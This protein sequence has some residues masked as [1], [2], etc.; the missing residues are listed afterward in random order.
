MAFSKANQ[1]LPQE[2]HF[3][4][5]GKILSHPVRIRILRKILEGGAEGATFNQINTGIPLDD[6]TLS[7]HFEY[8]RKMKIITSSDFKRTTK[9]FI[10]PELDFTLY[11]I[12]QLILSVPVIPDEDEAYDLHLLSK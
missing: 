4:L 8:L 7:H 11:R 9:H 10:N 5:M 3:A 12:V 1:F 6:S 2:Y